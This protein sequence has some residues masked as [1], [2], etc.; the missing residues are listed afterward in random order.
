MRDFLRII[1]CGMFVANAFFFAIIMT[2]VAI[3]GSVTIYE[4]FDIAVFEALMGWCSV[5][6]AIVFSA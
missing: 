3:G 1:V 2:S 4:N 5:V 6:A